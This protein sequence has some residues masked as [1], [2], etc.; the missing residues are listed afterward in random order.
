MFNCPT[1][2]IFFV[3]IEGSV[4]CVS[5]VSDERVISSDSLRLRLPIAERP[6]IISEVRLGG[7]SLTGATRRRFGESSKTGAYIIATGR[8]VGVGEPGPA[9]APARVSRVYHMPSPGFETGHA[10]SAECHK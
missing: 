2:I 9:S 8:P 6:A 7:T 3:E 10:S 1:N 5:R 4:L